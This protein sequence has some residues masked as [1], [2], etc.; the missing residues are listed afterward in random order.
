MQ[1]QI[2]NI[3]IVPYGTCHE[4]SCVALYEQAFPADER[5][6]ISDWLDFVNNH[7]LMHTSVI[8]AGEE[9]RFAGFAT[10]WQFSS[11]TYIEHFAV[12]PQLRGGGL[13]SESFRRLLLLCP[14]QP[15]IIEVELPSNDVARRRIAFY[16]RLGM[17]VLPYHYVQPP[18]S[19][20]RS[21]LPMLIM[22][23]QQNVL[24]EE[25]AD[26]RNELLRNVYGVQWNTDVGEVSSNF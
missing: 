9:Q 1:R 15:L 13:G 2:T 6:P 22:A 3:S 19:E 20:E 25:F 7:E 17:H 10:V 5:R 23:S 26:M 4:R 16:E 12:S 21:S 11:F 24:P 18:Y 14:N 8:L